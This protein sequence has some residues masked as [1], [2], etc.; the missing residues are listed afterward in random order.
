MKFAMFKNI[1]KRLSDEVNPV[2]LETKQYSKLIASQVPAVRHT[3]TFPILSPNGNAEVK[4]SCLVVG[5]EVFVGGIG[6]TIPTLANGGLSNT[7]WTAE[8]GFEQSGQT[9]VEVTVR[10]DVKERFALEEDVV[11]LAISRVFGELKSNLG[12]FLEGNLL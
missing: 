6:R 11:Y 1:E 5:D 10:H 8:D 3:Y 2:V 12:C 7:F 9:K 4:V